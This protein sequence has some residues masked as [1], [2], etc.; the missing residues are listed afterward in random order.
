[1]SDDESSIDINGAKVKVPVNL[2]LELPTGEN[3]MLNGFEMRF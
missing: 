1:M 3:E 2:Q